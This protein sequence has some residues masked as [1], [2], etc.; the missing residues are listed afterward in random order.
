MFS[1]THRVLGVF[2]FR[3]LPP[4][5]LVFWNPTNIWL[6]LSLENRWIPVLIIVQ[7]LDP[8]AMLPPCLHSGFLLARLGRPEV[9]SCIS[10]LQ[11][12]SFA[13][14]EAADQANEMARIYHAGGEELTHMAGVG[15]YGRTLSLSPSTRSVMTNGSTSETNGGTYL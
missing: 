10:G 11:Q 15:N 2:I 9:Q 13:Y 1:L 14:G 8:A 6:V 3:D 5:R 12:Y 4:P 7:R